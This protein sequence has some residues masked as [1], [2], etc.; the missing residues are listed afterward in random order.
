MAPRS[1]S[2]LNLNH[3]MEGRRWPFR[4]GR[5]ELDAPTAQS[6]RW[7]DVEKWVS[8][9]TV[10]AMAPR[11]ASALA[12][13]FLSGVPHLS[14]DAGRRS[15]P[16]VRSRSFGQ[17]AH[18]PISA[19]TRLSGGVA[20]NC[21]GRSLVEAA[22]G[23]RGSQSADLVARLGFDLGHGCRPKD[24]TRKPNGAEWLPPL[25]RVPHLPR[26]AQAISGRRS[27]RNRRTS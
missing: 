16:P 23:G 1:A 2:A 24:H 17:R 19:T 6:E 27:Q 3:Y 7:R 4:R 12:L 10:T 9:R 14:R 18:E 22:S 8:S 11:S 25:S 5:S 20:E 13:K 26:D 15:W 21:T